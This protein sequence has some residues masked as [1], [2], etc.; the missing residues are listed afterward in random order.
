MGA[1]VQDLP[2]ELLVQILGSVPKLDLKSARLTCIR[3]GN[4][5]S[6]WL[7]RRVYFAPRE[8]TMQTFT[9]IATHP[10]FGRNLKA[11]IYD[12]RLFL[13]D[14]LD[15][16]S[17]RQHYDYEITR[18]SETM[19]DFPGDEAHHENVA[20]SLAQYK[21][22]IVDQRD[23]FEG[24]KDFEVLS[25]GLR[26]LP[27][28]VKIVCC[29]TVSDRKKYRSI[30]DHAKDD[31][32][33]YENRS[34]QEFGL[35]IK[36]RVWYKHMAPIEGKWS[37]LGF[38]N[39]FRAV[40]LHC[41]SI[42]EL[43]I[44]SET[45]KIPANMFGRLSAEDAQHAYLV[46]HRLTSLKLGVSLKSLTFDDDVPRLVSCLNRILNEARQLRTISFI[47]LGG[48]LFQDRHWPH[49]SSLELG[50]VYIEGKRLLEITRTHKDRLREVRLWYTTLH[51]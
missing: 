1:Q 30:F 28:I 23:I 25:V 4:V 24:S 48:F 32:E 21:Q 43:Q 17:Y 37:V 12:R 2:D 27:N 47:G 29:D 39:F 11:L 36:P 16:E 33:W 8:A 15:F 26:M 42:K 19:V 51:R 18:K 46:A 31:H 3:W 45:S 9:N 10:V 22:F 49:L 5:G 13:D 6:K 7:F 50:D 14:L 20:L 34:T 38:E 41:P 44:G 40:S 35:A